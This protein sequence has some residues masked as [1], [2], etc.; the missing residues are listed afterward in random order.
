MATGELRR[1]AVPLILKKVKFI[2]FINI[3]QRRFEILL[4]LMCIYCQCKNHQNSFIQQEFYSAIPRNFLSKFLKACLLYFDV[5]LRGLIFWC[6]PTVRGVRIFMY[7]YK[8]KQ[9]VYCKWESVII[10]LVHWIVYH[11]FLFWWN[12]MF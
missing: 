7:P 10:C 4:W 6:R 9:V 2:L 8:K 3:L 5:V 1:V 11:F 12:F